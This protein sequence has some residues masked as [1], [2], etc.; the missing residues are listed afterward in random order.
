VRAGECA[1]PFLPGS[2]LRGE[3]YANPR[4]ADYPAI[5]VTWYNADRYCRW[6]GDR[7]PTEA[8]WEKAARWNPTTSASRIYPWGDDPPSATL[9]N[10]A[11]SINDTTEVGRYPQ[12]RSAVGAYDMAGNVWE[13]VNDWYDPNYYSYSPARNPNGP[14]SGAEKGYRGGSYREGPTL[15]RTTYRGHA[16]PTL[17]WIALGFRCASS[18]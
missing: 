16:N 15:V 4:Y 2:N 13:W 12:G 7:L 14:A 8:E 6:R 11:R 5:L 18:Q 3:Y 17:D 10:Y 1:A 9:L